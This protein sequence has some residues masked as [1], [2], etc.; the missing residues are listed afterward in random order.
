MNR[1]T[2]RTYHIDSVSRMSMAE[3]GGKEREDALLRLKYLLG[4]GVNR[5]SR[6]GGSKTRYGR[7]LGSI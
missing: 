7:F 5:R 4:R 6:K 3:G 1:A 2:N